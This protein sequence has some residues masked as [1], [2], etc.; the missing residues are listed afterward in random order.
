MFNINRERNIYVLDG[1]APTFVKKIVD[2]NV[3]VNSE[4]IFTIEYDANPVPDVKWFRNGLELTSSSRYRIN[5]NA[6]ESKSALTF[7]E[8]WENDSNSIISCEIMNPL[9]KNNCQAMFHVKGKF[10]S[11]FQIM[12]S[13]IN[14]MKFK[15]VYAN[16]L[17]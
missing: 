3:P 15:A 2:A 16:V 12:E 13:K 1:R 6:E 8:A 4:T 7:T 14:K 17:F 9:G 5:T 11:L 10:M